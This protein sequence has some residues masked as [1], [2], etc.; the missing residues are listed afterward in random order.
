MTPTN[1]ICRITLFFP[2]ESDD[3]AIELKKKI[4]DV[5]A[6][7]PDVRFQFTIVNSPPPA[8]PDNGGR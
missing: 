2:V 8:E 5:V 4:G 1:Q 6:D 3:K 7:I